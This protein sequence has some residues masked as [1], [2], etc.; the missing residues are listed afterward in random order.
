MSAHSDAVKAMLKWAL[1]T[2]AGPHAATLPTEALDAMVERSEGSAEQLIEIKNRLPAGGGASE[3]TLQETNTWLEALLAD[4][5]GVDLLAA[6]QAIQALLE[7]TLT[8]QAG[9]SRF[10]ESTAVLG[11]NATFTSPARA[12]PLGM[13]R[14][15]AVADVAG[16][17]HLEVSSDGNAPWLRIISTPATQ[18]GVGGL[19][20][21]SIEHKPVLAFSRWVYVNGAGAQGS[22]T[23]SSALLSA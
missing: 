22:F 14:G 10:A 7:G 21:A 16:T 6:L 1:Q 9:G 5:H 20:V 11:S 4:Q 8:V 2:F 15:L 12:V 3:A 18:V 13:L 23:L 19:Y 17:L